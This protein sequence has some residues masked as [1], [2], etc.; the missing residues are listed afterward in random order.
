LAAFLAAA[1]RAVRDDEAAHLDL[2]AEVVAHG[3]LSERIRAAL[4]PHAAAGDQAFHAA[5]GRLYRELADCLAENRPWAGRAAP[6]PAP[7]VRM[8]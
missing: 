2:A 4:E 7:A 5:A 3:S 8:P 6:A 1:R